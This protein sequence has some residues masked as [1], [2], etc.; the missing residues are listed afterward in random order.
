MTWGYCVV[1]FEEQCSPVTKRRLSPHS[2]VPGSDGAGHCNVGLRGPTPQ[3]VTGCR[4]A[5]FSLNIQEITPRDYL[6]KINVVL[7]VYWQ[8][9]DGSGIR[10]SRLPRTPP[11]PA[12]SR[13]SQRPLPAPWLGADGRT[14]G[15]TGF[16]ELGVSYSSGE[17]RA[18]RIRRHHTDTFQITTIKLKFFLFFTVNL[19]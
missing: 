13:R 11:A 2:R 14:D 10:G 4:F 12:R 1:L 19:F 8:P 17:T 3:R 5:G 7:R 9:C 6:N 18:W 16:P 15:R